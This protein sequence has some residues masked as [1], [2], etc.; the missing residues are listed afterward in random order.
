MYYHLHLIFCISLILSW[1]AFIVSRFNF[2]LIYLPLKSF[3]MPVRLA[4]DSNFFSSEPWLLASKLIKVPSTSKIFSEI[5]IWILVL[6]LVFYFLKSL[7]YILKNQSYNFVQVQNSALVFALIACFLIPFDSSDL[8]GYIARGW[9]QLTYLQNPFASVVAEIPQWQQDP[10][11]VNLLWEHN[12]SPYGPVFMMLCK[13]LTWLSQGNLW[14]AMLV[15]KLAN[16]AVFYLSL[17]LIKNIL[18]QENFIKD[19]SLKLSIFASFALNPFVI[20]QVL[21]NSHNDLL[22]GYLILAAVYNLYKDK[23]VLGFLFLSLSILIK[24]ISLVLLPLFLIFAWRKKKLDLFFAV[25]LST[26][27]SLV[28]ASHYQLFTIDY[29]NIASN[30]SLSHKSLFDVF[31]SLFKYV[32]KHDLAAWWRWVF[33]IGYC[34]YALWL[35]LKAV[36]VKNSSEIFSYSFWLIFVLLFFASPKFHSWYLIMLMPLGLFVHP[37]LTL[38]LSITHMLSF[39]FLDQANIANYILMTAVPVVIYFRAK[40]IPSS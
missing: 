27:L 24:Y 17:R 40:L 20:S 30:I 14:L 7:F 26:A 32:A 21:W 1:L 16:L 33:L 11:L 36:K 2:D 25:I 23:V 13:A 19:K 5:L 3:F 6:S 34:F 37:Q 38:I 35:Y 22:V 18:T 8:F 9:Q 10:M 29:S 4:A 39:T 28:L 15:F 31:N 12:P